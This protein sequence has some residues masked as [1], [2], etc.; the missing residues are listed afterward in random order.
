MNSGKDHAF[1]VGCNIQRRPSITLFACS[2]YRLL[3]QTLPSWMEERSR[4]SNSP[5]PTIWQLLTFRF[6]PIRDTGKAPPTSFPLKFQRIIRTRHP[7]WN[8]TPK[9][10]TPT[11]I[12]KE[13]SVWIFCARIG[14]PYWTL[15]PSFMGWST[16]FMN[17][18]LRILWT[19][20]RPNSFEKT[21]INSL[22]WWREHCVGDTWTEYNLSDWC[23]EEIDG[24]TLGD[25]V[26]YLTPQ[27]A[28]KNLLYVVNSIFCP[29]W[30]SARWPLAA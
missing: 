3:M 30:K 29:I 14:N 5:T 1:L 26:E 11:L 24:Q 22:D 6:A 9:S 8:V 7:K 19:T 12:Y 17:P 28:W 15:M 21:S 10:T 23:K 18:I 16:S 25:C 27:Y 4:L 2:P 20:R 13:K